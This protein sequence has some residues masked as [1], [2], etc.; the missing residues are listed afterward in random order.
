MKTKA[1][2]LFIG[3][4][5]F[6]IPTPCIAAVDLEILQNIEIGATPVDVAVSRDGD[7]IYVLTSEAQVHVYSNQGVLQGMV[8]VDAGA[9]KIACGPDDGTLYVTNTGKQAVNVLRLDVVHDFTSSHS[10]IK[11]PSDAAIT[12][13]LFTDFECTYCAKLAPIIDQVHLQYP[14]NVKIVFRNYPLRMH[15]FAM[16][17]ALAAL[18]ANEQ[19]QFW[20]FHDRLFKNYNRLNAQ[21]IEEIRQELDLDAD[22]FRESMNKPALKETIRGDLQDGTAAGVKGTPTVF[23]NGKKMRYRLSLAGFRRAIEE[24]LAQNR[25]KQ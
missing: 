13:T 16:Q 3:I 22:Q 15:R 21:K 2:F 25:S 24:E 9:Q 11:G 19:G 14:E 1:L 17:A 5:I 7:W 20:A 12:L 18:A 23:I 4:L 10:P 8:P 6:T